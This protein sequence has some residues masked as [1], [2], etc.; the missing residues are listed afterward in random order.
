VREQF[1][2]LK[3]QDEIKNDEDT[4][5]GSVKMQWHIIDASKSIHEVHDNIIKI[6]NEVIDNIRVCSSISSNNDVDN[7]STNYNNYKCIQKL[8]I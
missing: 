2:L 5:P 7:S 4:T 1:L 6:T 3:Q 8:W